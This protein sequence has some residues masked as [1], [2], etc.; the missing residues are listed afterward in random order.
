MHR[1]T[2]KRKRVVV[3]KHVASNTQ[4]GD[5]KGA[6]VAV[7]PLPAAAATVTDTG[8]AR[9][10]LVIAGLVFSALL[11][12]VVWAIPTSPARFTHAGQVVMDHQ[13]DLVLMGI[14]TL[15]MT[16]LLFLLTSGA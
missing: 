16:I 4:T 10:V 8:D 9:N 7:T 11:F 14:G 12:F 3:H 13:T 1:P 6:S 2:H 5:V 15:L